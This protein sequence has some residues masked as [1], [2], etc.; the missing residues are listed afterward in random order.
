LGRSVERSRSRR[1][2]LLAVAAISAVIAAA[3]GVAVASHENCHDSG[4]RCHGIDN[5]GDLN[6]GRTHPHYTDKRSSGG[7]NRVVLETRRGT[8]P[9]YNFTGSI[10]LD[11]AAAWIFP[12]DHFHRNVQSDAAECRTFM[13]NEVVGRWRYAHNVHN[14]CG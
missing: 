14:W 4:A 2:P 1:L 5:Y 9:Q 10:Q 11:Y 7:E 8:G 3:T 6:D 12:G 13:W